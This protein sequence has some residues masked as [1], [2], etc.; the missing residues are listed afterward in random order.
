MTNDDDFHEDDFGADV[1]TM[2]SRRALDIPDRRRSMPQVDEREAMGF[3]RE[4][5]A[6]RRLA[7]MLAAAAVVALVLGSSYCHAD[8]GADGR[9][10]SGIPD[11]GSSCG[12]RCGVVGCERASADVHV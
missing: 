9:C 4:A 1:A 10:G 5:P 7:P 3:T 2:L 11:G 12:T 8:N 6:A